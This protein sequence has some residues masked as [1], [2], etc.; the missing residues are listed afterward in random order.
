MRLRTTQTK[1]TESDGGENKD[2]QLQETTPLLPAKNNT[3][4]A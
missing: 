4:L 3:R 2:K 1:A